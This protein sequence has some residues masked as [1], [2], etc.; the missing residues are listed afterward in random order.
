MTMSRLTKETVQAIVEA[1][2]AKVRHA[3]AELMKRLEAQAQQMIRRDRPDKDYTPDEASELE[4][5]EKI[6]ADYVDDVP[7]GEASFKELK[8]LLQRFAV[9]PRHVMTIAKRR[10]IEPKRV[11]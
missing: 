8:E 9:D 3:R 7:G 6:I 11:R 1:S 2:R 5:A 4:F 10:L